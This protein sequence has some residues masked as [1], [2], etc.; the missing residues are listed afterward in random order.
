M[1]KLYIIALGLLT[2]SVIAKGSH[3]KPVD[4][5]PNAQSTQSEPGGSEFKSN[6]SS[7]VR[8][9]ERTQKQSESPST[10]V[11]LRAIDGANNNLADPDMGKAHIRLSRF[12]Q[13][14]YADGISAIDDA[15]PSARVI[16]NLVLAQTESEPNT[17]GA[18]D[19]LWQ[20]GQFLDHDIDLTDGAVPEETVSISVP[21]GD[22]YFDPDFTGTQT[23]DINR[24]LYDESTGTSSANPRQQINEIT[25]WIDA[26][27]VYG[28][29]IDRANG[30]RTLDGSGRLKVSDGDLLPFN[31]DGLVN[32]GGDSPALFVAGDVRANE[33]VGLTVMHTLFV[34]EHN[35]LVARFSRDN[36]SLNGEEL[37]QKARGYV[38][39]Q[40][41]IITYKEFLPLILGKDALPKYQGYRP[42]QDADIANEFST[43]AYRF[44]HTM[45]SPQILRLDESLNEID[46]G[47]LALRDAF[48]R[49]DRLMTEGGLEPI[50]RGLANQ[51]SQRIDSHVIDDVRNFLF[52]QPGAGG[53]D[54]AAIN[55]QRGRDHGLASFN[56]MRRA[57]GLRPVSRFDEISEKPSVQQAL[58]AAYDSVEDIDLWVGGLAE[59]PHKKAMVGETFYHILK[60]QFIALREGDRFWYRNQFSQRELEELEQTRLSDIIR[61]NTTIG[62]EL[63][64]NVFL[65]THNR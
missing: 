22:A 62:R 52:G 11:D 23:I 49:P 20:W 45:L 48:F 58:A 47:H 6:K 50:L 40:M 41:Q 14:N 42:E 53:F 32:A 46:A 43:A 25:A 37:Y 59:D 51:V 57:L 31:T 26:S 5:N 29:D 30:L 4:G 61:R 15:L 3:P 9:L 38:A 8:G 28:S 19:Y 33:Q 60:R 56:D 54:L 64:D 27:N 44:G 24:S 35:R 39:A 1:K 34:R 10:V 36:P 21:E 65:V 16:S 63:Q 7:P 55:I 2:S 18:S 17:Y 13:A 12:G